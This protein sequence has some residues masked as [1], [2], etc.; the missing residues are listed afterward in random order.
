MKTTIRITAHNGFDPRYVTR[1]AL[2]DSPQDP[3]D[4]HGCV[5][6][7]AMAHPGTTHEIVSLGETVGTLVAEYDH[8]TEEA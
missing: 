5:I 7:N 1:V 6:T 4:Y 2:G 8:E 3:E